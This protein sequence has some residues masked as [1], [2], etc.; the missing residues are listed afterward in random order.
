MNG[1]DIVLIAVLAAALALAVRHVW[2]TRKTG[3]C[4]RGCDGCS[5]A[6]NC[7]SKIE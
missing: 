5:S 3:G 4:G 7:R 1:I 6:P 2:K